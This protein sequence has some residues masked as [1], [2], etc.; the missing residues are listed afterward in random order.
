[1]LTTTTGR[2]ILTPEQ[3]HALVVQPTLQNAVAPQVATV[4][5]TGASGFRIPL[6]T[7]DPTAAWVPE[8]EE[9]PTSDMVFDEA[10]AEFRKLAGLTIITSELAADTANPEAATAVGAGLARDMA[11]TLDAAFFGD[12]APDEAPDGLGALA[13]VTEIDGGTA[14]TNTDPFVEAIASAEGA[15]AS[16]TTFV[17]NPA[18]ALA[19]AKVK[20][21][22]GS[23]EPLLTLQ[24]S[25]RYV[26]G[27]QLRTSTAVA[28]GTLWGIPQSAAY[29]VVRDDADVQTDASV[30][31]TSDRVAVR[32]KM[33]VG[34]AFPH[35]AAIQKIT[36][37]A[38]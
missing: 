15:T 16:I 27:V 14:I 17:V 18:D 12:E 26:A 25:E 31:F 4:V 36:L 7:K 24:G 21:A 28:P 9:I 13:G 32:G 2:S 30:Y 37:S 34:F 10:E 35:P 22:T 38:A 6:V 33:R 11:R 20:K 1:M 3:I 5:H 8:G 23:N 19:L 29:L